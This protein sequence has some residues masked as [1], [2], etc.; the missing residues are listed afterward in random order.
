MS[1]NKTLS[2]KRR[3]ND[4]RIIAKQ[5]R[6]CYYH[7]AT[8]ND[9]VGAFRKRKALNCGQSRCLMCSNPRRTFGR[10]TLAEKRAI[11]AFR[12]EVGDGMG[13]DNN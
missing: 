9:P 7:N 2:S 13:R 3:A 6:I 12:S 11:E 1:A 5:V 8:I 10:L 4:T